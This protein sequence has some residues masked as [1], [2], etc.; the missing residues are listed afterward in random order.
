[1]A[2]C[3]FLECLKSISI[4]DRR[5]QMSWFRFDVLQKIS[6]MINIRYLRDYGRGLLKKCMILSRNSIEMTIIS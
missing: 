1:M 4:E 5:C 3:M 2:F 6:A